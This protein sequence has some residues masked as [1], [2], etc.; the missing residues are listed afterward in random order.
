VVGVVDVDQCSEKKIDRIEDR[1]SGIE[2][3]LSRLAS[4]LG[5]LDLQTDATERSSQSRPSRVGSRVGSGKSPTLATDATTP[6]P[7][8]GETAI[9]SQSGYA[10]ALLTK[11]VGDTPSIGQNAEIK[12]ALSALGDI[13]KGQEHI[14]VSTTSTT[15]SLINRA[16]QDLDPGK[17]ERPPWPAVKEMLE[18]ALSRL[19]RPC[20]ATVAD[21]SQSTQQWRLLSFSPSSKCAIS[22][23]SSRMP[24]PI[25][26]SVRLHAAS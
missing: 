8:E 11:V 3:V 17:L 7:F 2:N 6:A 25:H 5:D 12:S 20:F 10:R 1:L 16:L 14:T 13:V 4:K 24:T 23:R 22:S 19:Q 26:P 15:N 18:R 21:H 9:N